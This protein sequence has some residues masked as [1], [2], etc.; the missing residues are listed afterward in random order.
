MISSN[1]LQPTRTSSKISSNIYLFRQESALAHRATSTYKG[2]KQ[3][4]QK[5]QHHPTSC[6][7]PA[8]HIKQLDSAYKEQ[9][10][11][12]KQ[13][14]STRKNQLYDFKQ[15][16]SAYKNQL[17]HIKQHLPIQAGNSS[18]TK[19][20]SN[21]HEHMQE[22]ALQAIISILQHFSYCW[23]SAYSILS[24]KMHPIIGKIYA[25]TQLSLHV[26]EQTCNRVIKQVC[27]QA[28]M[29]TNKQTRNRQT[30]QSLLQVNSKLVLAIL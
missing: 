8:Y 7:V 16:V 22:P 6:W 29:Q 25:S 15:L 12:F 10:Y 28:S 27:N 17:S 1:F 14:A 23:R 20:P 11:H 4:Y 24:V 5:H 30:C 19:Q 13:L 18:T 2:R 21:L 3:L 26:F 9:L